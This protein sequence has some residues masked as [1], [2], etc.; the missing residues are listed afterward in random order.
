MCLLLFVL[1]LFLYFAWLMLREVQLY[2]QGLSTTG[3]IIAVERTKY[4]VSYT[5]SHG[6]QHA[7]VV[8][9]PNVHQL[10]SSVTLRYLPHD[11]KQIS[12]ASDA[13]SLTGVAIGLSFTGIVSLLLLAQLFGRDDIINIVAILMFLAGTI[14]LLWWFI[15]S[16]RLLLE[17]KSVTGTVL[18]RQ[19]TGTGRKRSSQI[20]VQYLDS[21]GTRHEWLSH[22]SPDFN[23]YKKGSPVRL[24][25][26]KANPNQA[27]TFT[28]STLVI[29][30][31]SILLFGGSTIAMIMQSF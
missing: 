8:H 6:I 14:Y 2:F 11:P 4:T 30:I 26:L 15:M 28:Y 18:E 21:S 25:Y 13:T 24:L 31:F 19:E 16:I 1:P 3:T 23:R 10:G 7:Q 9:Y 22:K 17:S 5:D 27:S 29:Q 12:V 20:L